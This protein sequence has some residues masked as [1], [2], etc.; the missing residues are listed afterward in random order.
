MVSIINVIKWLV[1]L[2]QDEMQF[3][4]AFV[5]RVQVLLPALEKEAKKML[6]QKSQCFQGFRGSWII[7]EPQILGIYLL[8]IHSN[9]R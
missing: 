7:Q 8:R 3:F 5:S 9:R 6:G 2:I 1:E 4:H